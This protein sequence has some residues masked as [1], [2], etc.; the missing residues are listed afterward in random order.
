M[1]TTSTPV[2]SAAATDSP[3]TPWLEAATRFLFFTGKG[4]VGKTTVAS[5]TALRLAESG[6]RVLIVST[7][8]A[9]NL[10]DVF[11]MAAGATPTEVPGAAGLWVANLDP[12]AAAAAYR[13]QL[14]G[15][16]RGVLPDAA[17]RSMEEQLSG[18]CTVEIA[19]FNEFT[20]LLADPAIVDRFDHVVFDTAPTGHTLRLLSL[21]SAWSDFLTTSSAGASCLGPLA[22]LEQHRARYAATVEALADAAQTTV[23]LV[24]RAE[25]STLREAA[26]AGG[27]LAALGIANQR[28]VLNGVLPF[29][30]AV[31]HDA[32]ASALAARQ[33]A[34]LAAMAAPLRALPVARIPLVTSDLTGLGALRA[35]AS[36]QPSVSEET[37]AAAAEPVAPPRFNGDRFG[38]FD[39]LVRAIVHDGGGVVMTMGKGG[40]GKT[41]LAARLARALAI[42]GRQVHLS[43]TDPAA[44]VRDAVGGTPPAGLVV[45][46]IDPAAETARYS[47]EVLAAAEEAA[48]PVGG[49]DPDERAML[50]ED[51]RSPCTEE[52][53]V[54]R[55]FARTVAEA[56]D[57]AERVVV[58]DT[59]PTGHTL[60]LLDAAE[61]YH[62]E[63][64]R[65]TGAHIPDAVRALLPRLRDAHYT[66]MLLVTLAEATPV[67]EATR[68]QDDLRR[69]GIE[70]FGWVVNASLAASGTRHPLLAARARLEGPHLERGCALSRKSW[71]FPGEAATR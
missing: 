59:A 5:A 56:G 35:L 6:R 43:T 19:A 9:S 21:P 29:D 36:G 55:A 7:D 22:G 13:E 18:A 27:E 2:A 24:S 54:F 57:D 16:Y 37:A 11:A 41:T 62:R 61:S 46:R 40:V 10:D 63:V 68:L 50:E 34:A 32:V 66:K 45:S 65:T 70:P 38:D 15:P 58:L 12:V 1:T 28:L 51:L 31:M 25:E 60:L 33:Q 69:A 14:V 3:V 71:L 48:A 39:A 4:G 44:H 26:R 67:L 30:E 53:A 42:A 8:P 47:A 17:I 20:A 64:A 49:L 23:V 52:I